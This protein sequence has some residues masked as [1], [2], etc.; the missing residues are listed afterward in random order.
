MFGV[1]GLP[2][3]SYGGMI[4]CNLRTYSRINTEA[5]N[6]Y[7]NR[8]KTSKLNFATHFAHVIIFFLS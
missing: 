4:S 2:A 5:Y 7:E 8:S 3:F 6:D 1:V